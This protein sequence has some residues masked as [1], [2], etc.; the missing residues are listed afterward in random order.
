MENNSVFLQN[1]IFPLSGLA[2]LSLT[3]KMVIFH[4]V[5]KYIFL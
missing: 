1:K 2:V 4:D 3:E 5:N